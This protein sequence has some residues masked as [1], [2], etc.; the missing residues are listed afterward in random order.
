MHCNLVPRLSPGPYTDM[1][2]RGALIMMP[3][4]QPEMMPAQGRVMIHPKYIQPTMRQLMVLH[5]PA[6]SPTPTVAPE[7][8]WVVETGSSR[9]S[10]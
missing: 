3:I 1:P 6:V 8:H 5:V 2:H 4:K 7:I 10:G 9:R